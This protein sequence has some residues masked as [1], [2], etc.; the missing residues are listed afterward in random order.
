MCE[1]IELLYQTR[2]TL[3]EGVEVPNSL[4]HIA[5]KAYYANAG[6]KISIDT[7]DYIFAIGTFNLDRKLKYKEEYCYLPE[8]MWVTYN[9]DLLPND[10]SNAPHVFDEDCYYKICFK[11]TDGKNVEMEDLDRIKTCLRIDGGLKLSQPRIKYMRPIFD[12]EAQRV[13]NKCNTYKSEEYLKL[14]LLTDTHNVLNGTWQ[15]TEK[16]IQHVSQHIK[17]DAIVHLGDLS[18]GIVSKKQTLTLASEV[19]DGLKINDVPVY[20]ALGNHDSNYFFRNKEYI[21]IEEQAK[22]Y[23][24]RVK[25]YYYEDMDTFRLIFLYSYDNDRQVRYGYSNDQIDWLSEVL[26]KTEVSKKVLIFS[27]DAPIAELDYWTDEIYNGEHLVNLLEEHN[28][29]RKNI[30]AL[31]H[32]HTHADNIHRDC[33]F[34]IVSIANNKCEDFTYY[35]PEGSITHKRMFDHF[36]QDLWDVLVLNKNTCKLDL[37]R[38][39]AGVDRSVS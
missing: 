26:N 22:L 17:P 36:T 12:E 4:Q 2:T 33:S 8:S 7:Q 14:I 18:D 20:I 24:N 6:D 30:L 31:I 35:K 27:H 38:F 1:S 25:P 23:L 11:R 16:N 28:S 21:S 5:T 39:G 13:I 19:I 9:Q 15:D 32:G 10:Y 34:P 37:I 3:L 29:R